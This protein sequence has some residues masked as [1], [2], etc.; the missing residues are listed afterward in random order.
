[1]ILIKL[2]HRIIDFSKRENETSV[3]FLQLDSILQQVHVFYI[4]NII[5]ATHKITTV[6]RSILR[7]RNSYEEHCFTNL[8]RLKDQKDN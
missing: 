1:M 7:R 5:V 3:I 6:K 8:I 4:I 2:N